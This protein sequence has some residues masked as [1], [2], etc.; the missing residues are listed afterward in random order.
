MH[1]PARLGPQCSLLSV[2]AC[3]F[4][5]AAFQ[6]CSGKSSLDRAADQQA[7]ELGFVKE[8]LA[9]LVGRVTIDGQLP[10][11]DRSLLV[12]LND[13]EH[14]DATANGKPP[15]LFSVCGAQGDFTLMAKPG[16]YILTFV[17][18]HQSEAPVGRSRSVGG[19]GL[20]LD[21]ARSRGNLLPP[22]DLK[23][24]YNDPD[25]NAKDEKFSVEL[26]LPGQENYQ[27]DLAVADK[28]AIQTPG[29]HAVTRLVGR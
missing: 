23:N 14:L 25:K 2:A 17:E 22:D 4:L 12:I 3:L 5:M 7:E 29:P 8:N 1:F 26:K 13:P 9:K 27:I 18:L 20:G 21:S 16:K 15:T 11:E 24:L 10:A 28:D 6:G 19:R